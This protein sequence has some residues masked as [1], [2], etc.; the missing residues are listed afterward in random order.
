MDALLITASELAL[1]SAGII[2]L[3]LSILKIKNKIYMK[4]V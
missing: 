1:K 4:M 3:D 2:D